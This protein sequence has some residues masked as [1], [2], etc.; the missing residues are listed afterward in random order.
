MSAATPI[1]TARR[2]DAASRAP[3]LAHWQTPATDANS[4]IQNPALIRNRARDLVRNNPWANKA[5]AVIVNNTVG[6]GI[7]A[8]IHGAGQRRVQKVREIWA[9]WAETTACDADG[10]HDFYGLQQLMLRALVESGECL[11][12][13]RPRRAEDGLPLPLQIQVVEPDLLADDALVKPE[14]GNTLHA[15]IEF[16]ALGRRV[17]YHLYRHHPGAT[18]LGAYTPT[19]DTTRVPAEQIIH[20][21]RKDRPGQDRGVSWLLPVIVTLRELGIYEDA[22][23]KRQQL[24]NLF[25]GFISSDDPQ[26]F[27][28]ELDDEL[29]DLQPG[30]MYLLKPDRTIEF[31]TPPSAGEDI[32]YRDA[33]LRAVAAGLGI[34]FESLTGNLSEVNFSSARMGA[35]EMGRN[36]DAWQWS[37]F[38]PRVCQGV[39]GWFTALLPSVGIA[40]EGLRAEWTPPARTL[41]DPS[42]EYAALKTAVRSGFIS[43]PEAIRAQGYDPAALLAEQADYL[44]QLDAAG[45]KVES[46][47][48][49]DRPAATA[50][51]G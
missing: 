16:D 44:A 39:F 42:R 50:P 12:R 51:K 8:Q 2:Y 13:L 28:E 19:H 23:L 36:I 26:A 10:L 37:L 14:S 40:P 33:C 48:R 46:D 7:R 38:I 49:Q 5:L 3:R 29:P 15:G 25:A 34:T 47:Y 20:L 41:V 24:A 30:T 22:Y 45:V 18:A 17:A 27:G 6:Y 32:G 4:A 43:L 35:H 11:I 31:N 1:R 9:A 21:F